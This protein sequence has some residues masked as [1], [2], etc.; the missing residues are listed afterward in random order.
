MLLHDNSWI[1]FL[2]IDSKNH[3]NCLFCL[4]CIPSIVYE[5]KLEWIIRHSVKQFQYIFSLKFGYAMKLIVQNLVTFICIY[6]LYK[7]SSF[8]VCCMSSFVSRGSPQIMICEKALILGF[9]CWTLL[10]RYLP[11]LNPLETND[12]MQ[13]RETWVFV[14]QTYNT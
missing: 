13:H 10:Q 12:D 7:C 9:Y 5:T 1:F 3:L 6:L 14:E 2:Y 4:C 11:N 8:S